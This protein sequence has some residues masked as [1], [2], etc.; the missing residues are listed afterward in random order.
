MN[1]SVFSQRPMV[2]S[3][4]VCSS[5]HFPYPWIQRTHRRVE[6]TLFYFHFRFSWSKTG[7]RPI[8][9]LTCM[10]MW[11]WFIPPHFS[12]SSTCIPTKILPTTNPVTFPL[13]VPRWNNWKWPITW[14]VCMIETWFMFLPPFSK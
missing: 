6:T 9:W 4:L 5:S 2:F 13:P 14:L 10:E 8:T 3:V 12:N 11:F 1:E 7:K